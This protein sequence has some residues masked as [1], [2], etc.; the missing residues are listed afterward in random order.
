MLDFFKKFFGRRRDAY[1][2]QESHDWRSMVPQNVSRLPGSGLGRRRAVRS[3]MPYVLT[4]LFFV[5]LAVVLWFSLDDATPENKAAPIRFKTDGFLDVSYVQKIIAQNP[6]GTAREVR[7]IRTDLE[8]DNQVLGAQVAR[9]ADGSLD[10][11]LHERVAVARVALSPS[12]GGPLA[13]RLVSPEGMTF[14]GQNYPEQAIRNLPL[15]TEFRSSG[16]GDQMVID[17]LDIAGA[18]LMVA[19]T[20]FPNHYKQWEAVSLRD[21]FGAQGDTPSSSLHVIMRPASQPMDRPALTEIIFST[22]DWNKEL[23]LLSRLD[24]EGLLRRPAAT[25]S[26][27]VLKLSIQNRTTKNPIPEPRLVPVTT[28]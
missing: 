2:G 26:A 9:R 24:L 7:A 17:G 28:R 21:C 22:A 4:F 10:V 15:I 8:A 25:A 16:S 3:R 27:Y 19:R 12:A 20:S 6:Q 23:V 13:V 5:G 18:F 11:S 14:A 1:M